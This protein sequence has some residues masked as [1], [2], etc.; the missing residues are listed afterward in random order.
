MPD[1]DLNKWQKA[2]LIVVLERTENAPDHRATLAFADVAAAVAEKYW[3]WGRHLRP[4]HVRR[5]L[6]SLEHR[7]LLTIHSATEESADISRAKA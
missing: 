4:A 1:E 6:A 2:V 7:G 5:N 3:G